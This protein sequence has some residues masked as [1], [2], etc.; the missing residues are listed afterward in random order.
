[1]KPINYKNTFAFNFFGFTPYIGQINNSLTIDKKEVTK[2]NTLFKKFYSN[3]PDNKNNN[4]NIR[5]IYATFSAKDTLLQYNIIAFLFPYEKTGKITIANVTPNNTDLTGFLSQNKY[6]QSFIDYYRDYLSTIFYNLDNCS[7]QCFCTLS[8]FIPQH[9]IA[10]VTKQQY[11]DIK[12][13]V[14][15]VITLIN[16]PTPAQFGQFITIETKGEKPIRKIITRTETI[17]KNIICC[18]CL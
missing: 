16:P 2:A 12:T 3:S 15:S 4:T 13:G 10:K 8:D 17:N 18:K 11:I 6:T 7:K 14:T 9:Q 5:R 1:M